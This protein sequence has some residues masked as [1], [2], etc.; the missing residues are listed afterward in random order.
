MF[1]TVLCGKLASIIASSNVNNKSDW[2]SG[3]LLLEEL[4]VILMVKKLPDLWNQKVHRCVN[5]S[6]TMEYNILSSL[7]PHNIFTLYLS[8]THFKIIFLS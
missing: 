3:G 5:V 2:Y 1:E 7:N 6:S 8:N 4:I